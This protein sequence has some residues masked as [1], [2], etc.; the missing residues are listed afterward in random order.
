MY[1]YMY[2]LVYVYIG[3]I[4]NDELYRGTFVISNNLGLQCI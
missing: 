4:Q 2:M 1:T 3:T